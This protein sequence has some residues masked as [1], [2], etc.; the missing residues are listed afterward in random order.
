MIVSFSF[1]TYKFIFKILDNEDE[2]SP[3]TVDDTILY[4][5]V[6]IRSKSIKTADLISVIKSMKSDTDKGFTEEFNVRTKKIYKY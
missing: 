2:E 6:Q 5:T 1:Y 4:T 3:E